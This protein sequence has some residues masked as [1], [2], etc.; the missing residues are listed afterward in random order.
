M[1][2]I[3][4]YLFEKYQD[5]GYEIQK[6]MEYL[7]ILAGFVFTVMCVQLLNT[8]LNTFRWWMLGGDLTNLVAAILM[9]FFIKHGHPKLAV[10]SYSLIIVSFFWY[11]IFQALYSD[12]IMP[13]SRLYEMISLLLVTI[14]LLGLYAIQRRQIII[15]TIIANILYIVHF[16]AMVYRLTPEEETG[17]FFYIFFGLITLNLSFVGSILIYNLSHNLMKLLMQANKE[18]LDALTQVVDEFVPIC[19]NCKSI[20]QDDGSWKT[21]EDY[22]TDKSKDVKISHGLCLTCARKLYPD[23]EQNVEK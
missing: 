8:F 17:A 10:Y 19:A 12:Q 11:Y 2:K 6:K 16:S 15:H 9:F 14:L 4:S 7:F 3:R 18:K 22:I 20:R 13:L 1:N 23:F 21:I 5:E